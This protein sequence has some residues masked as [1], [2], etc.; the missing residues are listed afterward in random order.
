[1]E[2][3]NPKPL[4]PW[5]RHKKIDHNNYVYESGRFEGQRE[6]VSFLIDGHNRK[7]EHG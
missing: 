1:M 2:E 3:F 5:S 4:R 7:A 6:I